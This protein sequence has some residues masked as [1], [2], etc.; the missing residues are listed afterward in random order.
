MTPWWVL[1]YNVIFEYMR[2]FAWFVIICTILKK[3]Q[4]DPWKPA[5]LLKVTLVRGCFPRFLTCTN[6]T[7][8]RKASHIFWLVNHFV[9]KLDQLIYPVSQIQTLFNLAACRISSNTNYVEFTF[10][11]FFWRC[12]LKRSHSVC[13]LSAGV[14]EVE[15]P[16]KFS[17]REGLTGPH[18]WEWGCW[19]R[20]G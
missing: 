17:R 10:F 2:R 9:M 19:K 7:N 6:D 13:T 1:A 3:I 15:P 4:K 18:L 14:G 11:Y 8:L 12:A 16:T 20:G 5:T